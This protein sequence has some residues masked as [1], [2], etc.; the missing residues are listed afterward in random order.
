MRIR[1]SKN[2][3]LV[4]LCFILI[5]CVDE[6]QEK[7][8]IVED[9]KVPQ[10][11]ILQLK[12]PTL[13][14]QINQYGGAYIGLE[15]LENPLNPLTW[16]LQSEQMPP[17]NQKGAAFAGHFLCLGRWGSPSEGEIQAG[18]P[19]NGEP[20]NTQWELTESNTTFLKMKN[21]APLDYLT[22]SR[23]V[24]M[25]EQESS[26]L[27][28]ETF[29]NTGSIGRIS[30]VVQHI[31][32]GPP[33]LNPKMR[34]NTNA[35]EGFNQKFSYPQPQAYEATWP[36]MYVDTLGQ[37]IDL[38]RS[39]IDENYVSTHIFGEETYGWVYAYDPQSGLLL[40]Y[41]WKLQEYPW[42]NIWNHY[43][44]GKPFAKGLEFGTT[45]IGQ[46][47]AKLLKVNPQFH[48]HNSFEFI[49][50]GE[51]QEK[52]FQGF[53]LDIGK[54]SEIA[55]LAIKGQEI[56]ILNEANETIQSLKKLLD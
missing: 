38:R 55:S 26:F 46:P 28:K 6:N 53:M 52:S 10:D 23:A 5:A 11:Q 36:L 54:A 44:D 4:N 29:K 48:N 20:S 22:V 45:G 35:Q 14:L 37:Q 1:F 33:F 51:E 2:I 9:E 7:K 13:S 39:D 34:V 18:I 32:L 24:Q 15:L 8:P 50:A 49:D 27:V 30:N 43:E 16:K 40:G 12:N 31:T 56:Q 41:V 47:Y 21:T 42:I 17:N 25:A 3:L 19:H